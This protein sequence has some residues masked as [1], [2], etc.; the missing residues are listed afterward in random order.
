MKLIPLTQGQ[1]AKVD[2]EDFETLSK[3]KW[4]AQWAPNVRSFYA[5]RSLS[6]QKAGKRLCLRMHRL[7]LKEPMGFLVDHKN[8]DTLDNQ[9]ENLRPCTNSQNGLHRKARSAVS[10]SGIRGVTWHGLSSKWMAY[11]QLKKKRVHIGLFEN[12]QEAVAAY[13]AFSKIHHGEFGGR[14]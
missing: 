8:H 14:L 4:R 2:D 7:V 9:K 5:V 12:K 3:F 13:A 1:F 10:S 6:K 11:A